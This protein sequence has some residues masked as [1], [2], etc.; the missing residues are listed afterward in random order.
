MLADFYERPIGLAKRDVDG[1]VDV[2]VHVSPVLYIYDGE[3]KQTQRVVWIMMSR[4][5]TIVDPVQA[6]RPSS[7]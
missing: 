1:N 6:H 3:V 7:R 5:V 2:H 4:D